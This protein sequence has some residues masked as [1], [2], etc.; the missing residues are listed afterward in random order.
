MRHCRNRA[1]RPILGETC[2]SC[3]SVGD[4]RLFRVDGRMAY[5]QPPP[6]T[7]Q[8]WHCVMQRTGES[9]GAPPFLPI[10]TAAKAAETAMFWFRFLR[11]IGCRGTHPGK[12]ELPA[13]PRR[14]RRSDPSMS[15]PT[16]QPT[17]QRCI[18]GSAT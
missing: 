6:K 4:G 9:G 14:I 16:N 1:P 15:T 18:S 3:L 17:N 5:I 12:V 11:P 8:A 7:P 10:A 13:W 2:P